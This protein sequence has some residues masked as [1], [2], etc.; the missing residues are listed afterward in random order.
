[1]LEYV[2]FRA[3]LFTL[4]ATNICK[5]NIC[6]NHFKELMSRSEDEN[7]WRCELC[8]PVCKEEAERNND[9]RRVS[10]QLALVLW[11]EGQPKNTGL[12]MID[13]FAASVGSI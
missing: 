8:K 7:S 1:M 6:S 4:P 11:E 5:R 10:K 13:Q 9:I 2:F 3:A 12:F